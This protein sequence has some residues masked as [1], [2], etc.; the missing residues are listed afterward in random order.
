MYKQP[1]WKSTRMERLI[2]R[3]TASD[4]CVENG[5]QLAHASHE[6]D[7][8]GFAHGK[9]SLGEGFDDRVVARGHQHYHEQNPANIPLAQFGQ[10]RRVTG[11]VVGQH[12][13]L[14]VLAEGH[15]QSGLGH[16]DTH[17]DA[18]IAGWIWQAHHRPC[19]YMRSQNFLQPFGLRTRDGGMHHLLIHRLGSPRRARAARPRQTN[20]AGPGLWTCGRCAARTGR[21]HGQL[22]EL[23]TAPAFDHIPTALHDHLYFPL[24]LKYKDSVQ[25]RTRIVL[26]AARGA[27]DKN[28]APSLDIDRRVAARSLSRCLDAPITRSHAAR[29]A[30][31][32]WARQ[33]AIAEYI[34]AH[35][36]NPKAFIR[37][38]KVSAILARVVRAWAPLGEDRFHWTYCT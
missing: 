23:P 37:T 22:Y 38:A 9:Q 34:A 29:S 20:R 28:I 25:L 11:L 6:S 36:A 3:F 31:G 17:G 35:N 26:L 13:G 30:H 5:Q 2:P 14:G 32:G 16:V 19:L 1:S 18:G 21:R 33:A 12:Q 10:Q 7:L 15:L 8:L 27:T 24:K 4:H